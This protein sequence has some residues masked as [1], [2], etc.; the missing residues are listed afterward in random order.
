MSNLDVTIDYINTT[1][2]SP[3]GTDIPANNTYTD[4]IEEGLIPMNYNVVINA[5]LLKQDGSFLFYI[6]TRGFRPTDST[7]SISGYDWLKFWERDMCPIRLNPNL[8]RDKDRPALKLIKTQGVSFHDL[9]MLSH[10]Y[11]NGCCNIAIRVSTN[12]G[13]SGNLIFTKID[14][15]DIIMPSI[16]DKDGDHPKQKN[17]F[18][19]KTDQIT[20]YETKN[21]VV[22]DLS[23][24]RQISLSTS[25]T[26]DFPF[27]DEHNYLGTLT[28]RFDFSYAKPT[29]ARKPLDEFFRLQY[30]QDFIG[31]SILS[32]LP[33]SSGV[34]EITLSFYWDVSK[35][36]FSLAVPPVFPI[37]KT[38]NDY[39][40]TPLYYVPTPPS[41]RGN[42]EEGNPK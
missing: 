36:N 15:A 21:F 41:S 5:P 2:V 12:T 40:I 26:Y 8:V 34:N 3:I 13:Q 33:T 35:K 30:L 28:S 7:D 16:T 20:A 32:N 24:I 42:P 6:N 23:L 37:Y 22:S 29:I 18:N 19:N 14:G 39:D 4:V 38:K 31:V 9:K 1:T 27:W 17:L 11:N 25:S 10:R